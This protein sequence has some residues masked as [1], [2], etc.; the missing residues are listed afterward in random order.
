MARPSEVL[1]R[2]DALL[3][4]DVQVDFCPGGAL[5]IEEGDAVVPVPGA[6]CL[7]PRRVVVGRP[8][9]RALGAYLLSLRQPEVRE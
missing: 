5:P 3:I 9:A 6:L 7:G 1:Q 8:E 2:G 4:V